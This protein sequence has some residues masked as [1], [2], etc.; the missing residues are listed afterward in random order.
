[1]SDLDLLN[2][3]SMV[4]QRV[5][6]ENEENAES[7]ENETETGS[8]YGLILG[9][10]D[11]DSAPDGLMTVKEFAA[12]LTYKNFEAGLRG[13][14]AMV[15]SQAVYTAMKAKRHPLPVVLVDDSAY[16]PTEAFEAWANRPVRGEGGTSVAGS[17]RSDDDLLR[18]AAKARSDAM[19]LSDR[20]VRLEER[21]EKAKNTAVKYGRQLRER[22]GEVGWAK[23]DEWVSANEADSAISDENEEEND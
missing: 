13:V 15:D 12:E 18:L 6:E 23:V 21:L 16:L 2:E 1:M 11:D 3:M 17:R 22:F 8:K 7:A 9:T 10:Y 14:D 4:T 20:K 19:K 5:S